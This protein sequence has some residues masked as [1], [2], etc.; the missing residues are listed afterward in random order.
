M[1]AK[2]VMKYIEIAI[3]LT[4]IV[5]PICYYNST[6]SLH[7]RDTW[8]P[9]KEG[10]K[11]SI[12]I[13][14][15]SFNYTVLNNSDFAFIPQIFLDSVRYRE[16]FKDMIGITSLY[17]FIPIFTG[18]QTSEYVL[19]F[20]VTNKINKDCVDVYIKELD[21]NINIWTYWTNDASTAFGYPWLGIGYKIVQLNDSSKIY[22]FWQPY[23]FIP[24]VTIRD[25][26]R[27]QSQG[28]YTN[29]EWQW[30]KINNNEFVAERKYHFGIW[31]S[32]ITIILEP[33]KDRIRKMIINYDDPYSLFWEYRAY[34]IPYDIDMMKYLNGPYK[35]HIELFWQYYK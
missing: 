33:H 29:V 12:L 34:T 7:L 4:G 1:N 19:N 31:R 10:E 18:N 24:T 9:F 23:D 20:E 26:L 3:I 13:K 21:Q 22:Y 2:V 27:A 17:E 30:Y 15:F 11:F 5:F 28:R 35:M 16:D 14:N 6:L 25:S 32:N 8:I